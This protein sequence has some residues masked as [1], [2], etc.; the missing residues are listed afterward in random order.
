MLPEVNTSNPSFQVFQSSVVGSIQEAEAK[1]K[2]KEPTRLQNVKE[3]KNKDEYSSTTRD[4]VE[5]DEEPLETLSEEDKK[6][7][8]KQAA[9]S[10][11]NNYA[12]HA[13]SNQ[14][15]LEQATE[16]KTTKPIAEI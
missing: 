12:Q 11:N 13:Y 3:A 8:K 5:K 15:N 2:Q 1:R 4:P 7:R 14:Q 16:D 6:K 9:L 10:A